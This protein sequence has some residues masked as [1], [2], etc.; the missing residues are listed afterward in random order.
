MRDRIFFE[1]CQIKFNCFFLSNLLRQKKL[2]M[3]IINS[4]IFIAAITGIGGWKIWEPFPI[5]A[6]AMIL[7]MSVLKIVL[8]NFI[9]DEKYLLKLDDTH[10]FYVKYYNELE[11][12]WYRIDDEKLSEAYLRQRFYKELAVEELKVNQAT[13]EIMSKVI[14]RRCENKANKEQEIYFKKLFNTD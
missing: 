12:L 13:N 3:N 4:I 2:Y 9:G 1:M 11:E 5:I 14:G 8:P 6:C 10:N 7:F